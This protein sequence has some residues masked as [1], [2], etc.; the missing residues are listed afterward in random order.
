MSGAVA[1][2]P[3]PE[4]MERT[5]FIEIG[6]FS[7]LYEIGGTFDYSTDSLN[8]IHRLYIQPHLVRVAEILHHEFGDTFEF[9]VIS[10]EQGSLSIKGVLKVAAKI[11]GNALATGALLLLMG[12]AINGED[13]DARYDEAVQKIE[14]ILKYESQVIELCPE[15]LSEKGLAMWT[16]ETEQYKMVEFSYCPTDSSDV[17]KKVEETINK[18]HAIIKKS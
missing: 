9:T 6:E 3:M 16:P 11:S 15:P 10:I 14:L 4:P 7:L 5:E 18:Y 13:V 17:V 1:M 8:E 12:N 2:A